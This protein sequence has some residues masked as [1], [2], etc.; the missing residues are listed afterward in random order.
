MGLY[1]EDLQLIY[2]Q[3]ELLVAQD[4]KDLL[5]TEVILQARDLLVESCREGELDAS[6]RGPLLLLAFLKNRAKS[7]IPLH[8]H[9]VIDEVQDF[10]ALELALFSRVVRGPAALTLVGD[11]SQATSSA[12]QFPGWDALREHWLGVDDQSSVVNL[13]VSQRLPAPI[14]RFAEHISGRRESDGS[15]RPGKRPWAMSCQTENLGVREAIGWLTR[16]SDAYP[17][18]LV[19]VICATP[20]EAF[21]VESMLKP[22]FGQGVRLGDENSFSFAEG[23]VVTSVRQVKGLEFPYVLLWNPSNTSYPKGERGRNSLYVAATRAQELLSLVI[24]GNPSPHLP[25]KDSRLWRLR[26]REEEETED[27]EAA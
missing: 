23:I 5:D 25:A 10:G 21:L 3:P 9:L 1:L 24:W 4:R 14:V 20:A 27:D 7:D 2:S 16:V 12:K 22:S 15:E 6:D 11:L 26:T 18:S 8:S 13:T 19:V 17:G